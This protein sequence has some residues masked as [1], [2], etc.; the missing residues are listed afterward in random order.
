[1]GDGGGDISRS[2]NHDLRLLEEPGVPESRATAT[3]DHASGSGSSAAASIDLIVGES[4]A[5][6]GAEALTE[7][8]QGSSDRKR[9]N[10]SK[11]W[12]DFDAVYTIKNGKRVRT[13]G[14]CH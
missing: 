9:C 13:G 14:K 3:T 6:Q 8:G 10:T 7:V 4:G 12:D 11:V 5:G 2:I 1:M